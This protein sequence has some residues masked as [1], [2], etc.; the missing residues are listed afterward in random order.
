MESA[1]PDLS[2]AAAP[3][4]VARPLIDVEEHRTVGVGHE[5]AVLRTT[6][7]RP[8]YRSRLGYPLA[9]SAVIHEY[10]QAA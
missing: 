10:V 3:A 7:P 6:N 9:P 8:L 2:V 4:G 1:L 5:A